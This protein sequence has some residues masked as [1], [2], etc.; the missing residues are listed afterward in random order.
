MQCFSERDLEEIAKIV[1][2]HDPAAIHITIA[3]LSA[4]IAWK[5]GKEGVG[6]GNL[7]K[8]E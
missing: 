8:E 4:F 3:K 5:A 6:F 2:E 7:P 1:R